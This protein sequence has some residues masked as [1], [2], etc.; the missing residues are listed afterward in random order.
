MSRTLRHAITPNGKTKLSYAQRRVIMHRFK[1]GARIVDL[2]RDYGVQPSAIRRI[3]D[4]VKYIQR[5]APPAASDG[6]A[7]GRESESGEGES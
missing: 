5:T 2:A 6:A 3:T 4:W 7:D 1:L